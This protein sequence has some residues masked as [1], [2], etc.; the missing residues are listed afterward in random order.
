MYLESSP[1][2]DSAEVRLALFDFA[3][4]HVPIGIAVLDVKG[5]I[6]RGND[7]AQ[8]SSAYGCPCCTEL[9]SP[10]LPTRTTSKPTLPCSGRCLPGLGTAT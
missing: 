4:D 3:F 5:R 1:I 7:A 8:G 6:L 2:E 10:T 9:P